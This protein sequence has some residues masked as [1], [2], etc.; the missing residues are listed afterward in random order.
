MVP[1]EKLKPGPQV[2]LDKAVSTQIVA[3]DGFYQACPEYLFMRA[4]AQKAFARYMELM[5]ARAGESCN[6]CGNTKTMEPAIQ[7][8]LRHTKDLWDQHGLQG[9]QGLYRYVA[10]RLGY[11]PQRLVMYH[12]VEAGMQRLELGGQG[13]QPSPLN[14]TGDSGS[15]SPR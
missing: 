5:D 11:A 9:T 3:D 10:N 6:N 15:K 4:T 13:C 14:A 2:I 12:K 7:T 1:V 8:F